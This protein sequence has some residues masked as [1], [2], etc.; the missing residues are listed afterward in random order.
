M[1]TYRSHFNETK[2]MYFLIKNDKL[3]ERYN[4]IC[5]KVSNT[6]TKWFDSKAFYNKKYLRTKVKSYDGKIITNFNGDKIPK[7]R[8]QC[9]CLSVILIDSALITGKS[10]Y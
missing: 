5:D 10:Y 8:S 3:L 1:N 9:I 6:A 4:E 7:E 2:Y